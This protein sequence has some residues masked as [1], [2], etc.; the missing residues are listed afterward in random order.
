MKICLLISAF[1]ISLSTIA[2]TPPPNNLKLKGGTDGTLIGNVSDSI[3]VN[4]SNPS[5]LTTVYQGS[6]P[7][8]FNLSNIN[9]S[10][11]SVTNYIPSRITNG[12]SYVDPTQIRI[13]TAS[14]VVTANQG[15]PNTIINSWF[16][17]LSD[18]TTLNS[19]TV[20]HESQNYSNSQNGILTFGVDTSS[21]TRKW[22]PIGLDINGYTAVHLTDGTNFINSFPNITAAQGT[23]SAPNY[24]LDTFSL[25]AGW[26]GTTHREIAVDTVG[27][28]KVQTQYNP[29]NSAGTQ[30]TGNVSTVITLTHPSNAIGFL[31]QAGDA[32]TANIRWAVGATATTTV[33][34]QLQPGRDTKMDI[35]ADVSVVSES[36]TQE[37]QIQWIQTH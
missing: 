12:T 34:Q 35:G 2:D 27:Q 23:V 14:D 20:Q 26:D 11:P 25:V 24:I 19:V 5:S 9:G 1:F 18:P 31:L 16:T 10:I 36:G 15:L 29:I 3:K 33:G 8:D 6:P 13:L 21:P 32:N 4:V 17:T 28:I 30:V 7:W 37:Y 22:R